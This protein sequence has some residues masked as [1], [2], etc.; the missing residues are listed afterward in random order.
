MK[1]QVHCA[2]NGLALVL[3][4]RAPQASVNYNNAVKV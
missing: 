2:N 4:D 3:G 1:Y